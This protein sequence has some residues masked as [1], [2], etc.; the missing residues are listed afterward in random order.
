VLIFT[1]FFFVCV[2]YQNLN[3]ALGVDEYAGIPIDPVINE[4]I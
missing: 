1:L 4:G 3:I 2:C